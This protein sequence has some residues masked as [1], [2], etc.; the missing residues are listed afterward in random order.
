MHKYTRYFHLLFPCFIC[1]QPNIRVL[2]HIQMKY[3]T[4]LSI[5]GSDCSGGAGIQADIK[6]IS[7]LGCYAASIVT[8]VTVQ[9]TC[10]VKN[11]YPIPAQIVKEQI[12]AV[13]EDM[14]IDALKIGMVTDEGIIAVIADFLSSNRL[15]AVFDPVLVSSS[16]YSL[17]KPEALHVMRDRLIPHCTLVTPNLP[18]AEML[19]GIPIRNIED[20]ANAG[21]HILTYGCRSVLIKGGHLEGGDMTDILV[22]GNTPTEPDA[23]FLLLS[24]LTSAKVSPYR[25]LSV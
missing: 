10:G 19:S 12:Q 20:M 21:R 11:V 8:A 23:R 18:E 25:R 1:M 16:G 9:N 5:A 15:P 3:T 22:C 14:Q 2:L 17:V 13:T 4:V 6:T 7:A 24:R